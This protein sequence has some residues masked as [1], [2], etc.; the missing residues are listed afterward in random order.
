MYILIVFTLIKIC[1]RYKL[2][3]E[4]LPNCGLFALS[5]WEGF[6]KDREQSFP[7]AKSSN[8][9]RT[10]DQGVERLQRAELI[11]RCKDKWCCE[12]S[13]EF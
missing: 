4:I 1:H 8:F 11:L 2:V 5:C 7:V 12:K 6:K 10:Q 13:F 3:Q 9:K